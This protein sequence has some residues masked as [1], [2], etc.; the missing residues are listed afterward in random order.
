MASKPETTFIA[1]INRLIP[2]KRRKE[3]MKAREQYPSAIGYEKMNN[4]YSAGVAD[5]WY[6]GNKADL[7]VEY[8]YIQKLPIRP[9]TMIRLA[10]GDLLS[11]L[12]LDWLH[13]RYQEGRNVRVIVGCPEGGVVF[14]DLSWEQDLSTNDFKALIVSKQQIAQTIISACIHADQVHAA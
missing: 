14:E 9:S 8:K 1:S 6:S 2:L 10:S 4:P 11:A 7:W 5:S 13:E 12:Q 3:S